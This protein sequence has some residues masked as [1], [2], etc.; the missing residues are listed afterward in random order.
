MG[1]VKQ[2]SVNFFVCLNEIVLDIF[3]RNLSRMW[4]RNVFFNVRL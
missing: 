4:Y 1:G 3:S 2:F